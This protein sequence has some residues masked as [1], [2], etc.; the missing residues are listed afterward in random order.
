MCPQCIMYLYHIK[1]FVCF[2][3]NIFLKMNYFSKNIFYKIISFS[4]FGS[5]GAQMI[6]GP[7]P[8]TQG[9]SKGPS[10][11]GLWPEL[12][13]IAFGYRRG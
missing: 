9:E 4:L 7:G 5:Y 3:D 11:G 6:Y 1:H 13:K 12:D 2:N 10:R 8:S